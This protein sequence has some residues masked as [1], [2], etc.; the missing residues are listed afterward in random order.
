MGKTKTKKR[1]LPVGEGPRPRE[2]DDITRP[3]PLQPSILSLNSARRA[4]HRASGHPSNNKA[5]LSG[6]RQRLALASKSQRTEATARKRVRSRRAKSEE[7]GTKG[8]NQSM[9][10]SHQPTAGFPICHPRGL[11][12]ITLAL[13]D[14]CLC[15]LS[16]RNR[17]G[18][19]NEAGDLQ[20]SLFRSIASP[21]PDLLPGSFPHV[22]AS[23]SEVRESMYCTRKDEAFPSPLVSARRTTAEPKLEPDEHEERA[24]NPAVDPPS[25]IGNSAT[26]STAAARCSNSAARRAKMEP[27][28]TLDSG[29]WLV[30]RA[31]SIAPRARRQTTAKGIL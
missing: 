8:G 17:L 6:S 16:F 22:F 20:Y 7:R 12:Q 27:T 18:G 14:T 25:P 15:V 23:M 9:T 13:S 10:Q 31:R 24:L 30:R 5:R 11:A 19:V 21:H 29:S 1:R 3:C 28:T 2:V 4:G 26:Y